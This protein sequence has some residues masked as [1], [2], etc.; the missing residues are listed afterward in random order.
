MKIV[1]DGFADEDVRPDALP[2]ADDPWEGDRLRKTKN[3]CVVISGIASAQP[4]RADRARNIFPP[5]LIGVKKDIP[6]RNGKQI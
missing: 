3:E 1:F 6:H 4:L 2:T 5:T